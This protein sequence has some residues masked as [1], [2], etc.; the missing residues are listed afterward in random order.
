[1][2]VEWDEQGK[3]KRL[4]GIYLDISNTKKH[5]ETLLIENE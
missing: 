2:V 3:P 4:M 1:M 5:E